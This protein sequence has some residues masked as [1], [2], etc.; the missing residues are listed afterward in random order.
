MTLTTKTVL[1]LS[2]VKTVS[3]QLATNES[4]QSEATFSTAW[5]MKANVATG[6][7]REGSVFSLSVHS[8]GGVPRQDPCY[9]SWIGLGGTHLWTGRGLDSLRYGWYA[10]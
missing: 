2:A 5:R 9:P 10:S 6:S 8:G 4:L 3:A 1:S 7:V